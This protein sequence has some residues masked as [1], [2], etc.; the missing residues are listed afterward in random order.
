MASGHIGPGRILHGG[1]VVELCV[2]ADIHRVDTSLKLLEDADMSGTR[3]RT[4]QMAL[5]KPF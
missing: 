2:H 5:Y 3:L 4:Y 1:G